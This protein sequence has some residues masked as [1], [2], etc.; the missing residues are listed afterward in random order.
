MEELLDFYRNTAMELKP[1]DNGEKSWKPH[2]GTGRCYY[3]WLPYE[4]SDGIWLDHYTR[5]PIDYFHWGG[6]EVPKM[7]KMVLAFGARQPT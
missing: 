1:D 6:M 7:P 2:P 5:Q 4:L 3:F